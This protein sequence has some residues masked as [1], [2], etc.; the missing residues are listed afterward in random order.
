MSDLILN[1]KTFIDKKRERKWIKNYTLT[2]EETSPSPFKMHFNISRNL[3]PTLPTNYCGT[4]R[5]EATVPETHLS[6]NKKQNIPN[7]KNNK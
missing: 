7:K 4:Q 6:S 1:R 5:G 3:H 2:S